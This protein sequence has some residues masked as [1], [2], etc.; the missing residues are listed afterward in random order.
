MKELESMNARKNNDP[1]PQPRSSGQAD[2]TDHGASSRRETLDPP[3]VLSRIPDVTAVAPEDDYVR[4]APSSGQSSVRARL[5]SGILFVSALILLAAALLTFHKKTGSDTS[6]A[7]TSSTS[8][9]TDVLE[10]AAA[11]TALARKWKDGSETSGYQSGFRTPTFPPSGD[12]A[13]PTLS[14]TP[15]MDRR[16]ASQPRTAAWGGQPQWPIAGD[17][18]AGGTQN[19]WNRTADTRDEGNRSAAAPWAAAPQTAADIDASWGNQSATPASGN[20]PAEYTW[21]KPATAWNT[22][23][24]SRS[25]Q[26]QPSARP[27]TWNEPAQP[28]VAVPVQQATSNQASNPVM[29][30][31]ASGWNTPTSYQAPSN[32]A[33]SLPTPSDSSQTSP[34]Y[35]H[36]QSDYRGTAV[37]GYRTN[38]SAGNT[39][40]GNYSNAPAGNYSTGGYSTG[41]YSTGGYSTDNYATGN[42]SAGNRASVNYSTPNDSA[43]NHSTGHYSTGGNPTNNYANGVSPAGAPNIPYPVTTST[44]GYRNATPVNNYSSGS[45]PNGWQ[46]NGNSTWGNRNTYS[47]GGSSSGNGN[48]IYAAS[49]AESGTAQFEGGI[50]KPTVRTTYDGT[51]SSIR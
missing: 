34:T 11:S 4:S 28:P 24:S 8:E 15:G 31:R 45:T 35:N 27:I 14:A 50:D 40:T 37:N 47:A 30:S 9:K 20:L 7:S 42:Q 43:G 23:A 5:S 39:P 19:S 38:T 29:A 13:V 16:G 26:E 12:V 32:G 17:S 1:S 6:T 21:G 3:R 49:P 2:E 44:N 33:T 18:S 41:G 46:V 22:A 51:G 10:S 25:A 48:G 36:P